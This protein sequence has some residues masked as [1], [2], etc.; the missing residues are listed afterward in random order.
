[1]LCDR[2]RGAE[3]SPGATLELFPDVTVDMT[4]GQVQRGP[5]GAVD[6]SARVGGDPDGTADLHFDALCTG[7]DGTSDA[8]PDSARVAGEIA[9]GGHTYAVT[10]TSPGKV[11][12]QEL[13]PAVSE[14][15]PGEVDSPVLPDEPA[16]APRRGG[17]APPRART[18][19]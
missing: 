6:W 15:K 8:D 4:G 1:M 5:S 18:S 11:H 3:A 17:P 9:T 12:V 19:G 2:A 14:Y 7:P 16:A 10:S 13:N